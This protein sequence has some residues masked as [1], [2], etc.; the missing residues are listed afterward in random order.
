L[1]AE[2]RCLGRATG[3]LDLAAMAIYLADLIIDKWMPE[4]D[5]DD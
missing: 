4:G 3:N 2:D 5:G 1:P